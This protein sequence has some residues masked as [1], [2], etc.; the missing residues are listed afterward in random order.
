MK[1]KLSVNS[2]PCSLICQL[3]SKLLTVLQKQMWALEELIVKGGSYF[4]VL[5]AN[6]ENKQGMGVETEKLCDFR[7]NSKSAAKLRREPRCYV[8]HSSPLLIKLSLL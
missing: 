2:V 8:F 5:I 3:A 1:N 7:C 6:N 4:A